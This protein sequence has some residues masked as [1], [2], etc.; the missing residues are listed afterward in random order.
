MGV[1]PTYSIGNPRRNAMELKKPEAKGKA[2]FITGFHSYAVC[3]PARL[4]GE[5]G[6][7]NSVSRHQGSEQVGPQGRTQRSI[8]VL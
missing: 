6:H 2:V 7:Q 5:D 8:Q 4:A 1:I 3:K